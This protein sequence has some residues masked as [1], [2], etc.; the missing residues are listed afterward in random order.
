MK[1][2]TSGLFILLF[3]EIA[4]GGGGRLTSLGPVSLRMILFVIA[5]VFTLIASTRGQK[6]S[7]EYK[8]LLTLFIITIT[9]GW[10]RG[11][12][13]GAEQQYWWEDIKPLLYF[14]ILPFF[15]IT[16]SNEI[17]ILNAS[18]II[19][20]AAVFLAV[21]FFVA[22]FLIHTN[23]IPFLDFYALAIDTGEFFFRGQ[24]TFF[25]KGF[26]YLCIGL[27]FIHFLSIKN[28]TALLSLVLLAILLTFTRGFIL[29]LCLTYAGYFFLNHHYI[30][31]TIFTTL[32]ICIIAYGQAAISYTSQAIDIARSTTKTYSMSDSNGPPVEQQYI[33]K[34]NLLGNRDFSDSGRLQQITEV[35]ERITPLSFFMGHGFGNGVPSRP[36]HMEISY[37]EIFHKQGLLGL[38]FWGYIF[39]ML[40][41]KYRNTPLS[42][43]RDAFFCGALFVFFQS[44]TNQYINNPI[45]L[46]MVLVTLTC[47][48]RLDDKQILN[49]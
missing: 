47:L 19:R 2:I 39:F 21:A 22:L 5:S 40:L 10:I 41:Q 49:N 35:I 12:L 17:N 11:I 13:N 44:L 6:I 25:Y 43:M 31:A 14:F 1:S 34:K 29:A 28:K 27:I 46:S 7:K 4:I 18:R 42:P 26:L 30:K 33:P 48:D 20:F 3:S 9:I 38:A 32:A 16:F 24:V 45:G 36:V 15:A 37:L 8:I 23:I